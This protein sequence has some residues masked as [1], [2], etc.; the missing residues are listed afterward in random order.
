MLYPIMPSGPTDF[1]NELVIFAENSIQE[2]PAL[3][4]I[5]A[6]PLRL[7]TNMFIRNLYLFT[8][9]VLF[10]KHIVP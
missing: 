8:F 4:V 10:V 6:F 5:S 1:T 2:L 3:V 7:P 9:I